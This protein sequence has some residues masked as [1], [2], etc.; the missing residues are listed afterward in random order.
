MMLE[1]LPKV[2]TFAEFVDWL[3]ENT[4]VRYELRVSWQTNLLLLFYA[5]KPAIILIL[6]ATIA[7]LKKKARIPWSKDKRLSDREVICTSETWL[8]MPITKEKYKKS[9]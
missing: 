9:Q 7:V 6:I 8:V 2:T 1:T 5:I 3:P 4:G